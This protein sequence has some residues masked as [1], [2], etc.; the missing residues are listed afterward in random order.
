MC[1]GEAHPER[2]IAALCLCG[3]NNDYYRAG[4]GM[5]PFTPEFQFPLLQTSN[6]IDLNG[7]RA[8]FN[9]TFV[10]DT[11]IQARGLCGHLL[12]QNLDHCQAIP[13]NAASSCS[14]FRRQ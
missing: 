7:D 4:V 11:R 9:D 6:Q 1:L 5:T 3:R 14:G 8:A 13:D 10:R 2:T 12:H